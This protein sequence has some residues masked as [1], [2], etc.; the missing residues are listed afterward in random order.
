M[1]THSAAG[2][3][4][5]GSDDLHGGGL[6]GAVVP[7]Q[8]EHLSAVHRQRQPRQRRPLEGLTASAAGVAAA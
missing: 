8:P 7:Q 5:L 3:P 4:L 6:P 2:E 1:N